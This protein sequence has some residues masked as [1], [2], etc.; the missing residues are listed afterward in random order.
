MTGVSRRRSSSTAAGIN[1]GSS[2]IGLAAIGM[3][4]EVR[5]HAVERRS[6]GVEAAEQQEV[7][8]AEQL[9]M[10]ERPAVDVGVDEGGD[11]PAVGPDAPLRDRGFEVRGDLLTGA[12]ADLLVG[13][14][15]RWAA[16]RMVL[17]RH[18]RNIGRSVCGRPINVMK[19][20][21][22]N[23]V[24][25]SSWKSHSPRV[26]EPVDDLVHELAHLGFERGHL[27]R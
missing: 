16:G 5:D 6:H 12:L 26:D 7:A 9:G 14:P 23:G 11:Q 22:G 15:R 24:A 2:T 21:D 8:G 20:V 27:P 19:N 10:R 3:A 17:S 18:C 4:G 25:N 13:S 1:E